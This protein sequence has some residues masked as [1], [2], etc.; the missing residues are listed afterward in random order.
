MMFRKSQP[1][2]RCLALYRFMPWRFSL[3]AL[4]FIIVNAS[5][6]WQQWLIGRA[7]HDVERGVAVTRLPTG[8]LDYSV[9]RYWLLVLLTVALVRGALQ[10]AGGMLALIVGQDLLFILRERILVQV[11]RL[12]LIYHW[13]HG[14]GELVTR[15]TRDADK[16]RDAL[17]NLWRQVFETGLVALAAIGML[18]WYNPLLGLV[19]A[20][21]TVAGLSIFVSQTSQLVVLDRAVGAAYDAVSQD[22]SEG[23]NGVR[24]IKA[25]ALERRR[26]AGF[27]R[28]VAD[29]TVHARVALAFASS[30]IPLPQVVVALGQVWILVFGVHLVG[31]GELNIGELV[32]SLLMANTLVFRV[33]GVGRVMQVFADARSSA[34]RIWELLDSEPQIVGGNTLVPEGPLGVRFSNVRVASPGGNPILDGCSFHVRPGE[35]VALVGTTGS[36]KSTLTALLPRLL[37]VDDGEVA[38]GSDERGWTD[39]REFSLEHL[40]RHVHVVTQECFLFSDTLAANLRVA[41]PHASDAD[42]LRALELAAAADVIERLPRGLDTQLG[43]RGVTLSGGQRQR[44]CLARA[45]LAKASILGLDDATSALDAATERTVLRN[46]RE[47]RDTAGRNAVT[48]LVVS[49][50]LSTILMADRVL[51][52]ADGYIAAQG[53]HRDLSRTCA[54]YREL[55]G[56][57]NDG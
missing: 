21:L 32:A 3:T 13:R 9:A 24:V 31:L 29:F 38:I 30:R 1:L 45:L 35:I 23:V 50:K 10:Y 15:T 5:L 33:E 27:N 18:V 4:L 26:I 17:I 44:L 19:P 36:G 11:Q 25:F 8:A 41:D 16:V 2:L 57:E 51:L 37:Q 34:A 56:I 22:L 12:D 14:I 55:M 43:D 40:R 48:V 54:A 39:V 42:L 7:V 52:L 6:A 49:S 46:I 53:T 47:F 20:L 28:Q